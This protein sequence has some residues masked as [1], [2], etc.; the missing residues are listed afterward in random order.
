MAKPTTFLA[1]Q[2]DVVIRSVAAIPATA[3][4]IAPEQGRVVLAH[5]EATGHHHSFPHRAGVTLFRDDG[6][7][8]DTFLEVADVPAPLAH[9]EHGTIEVPPGTYRVVRQRTMQSGLVQ[10]VID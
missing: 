3:V 7:G 1:A 10:R 9:Q 4:P 6:A 8:G 2:G 5:G